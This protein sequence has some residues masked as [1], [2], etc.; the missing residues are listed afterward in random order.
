MTTQSK[1]RVPKAELTGLYGRL[2]TAYAKRMYGEVPDN[3]HVMWHN[4]KVLKGICGF[5]R[6]GPAASASRAATSGRWRSSA[7]LT[8][9]PAAGRPRSPGQ[10]AVYP[11][12]RNPRTTRLRRRESRECRRRDRAAAS[13][14][15]PIRR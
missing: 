15:L 10:W 3:A 4:R 7:I 6:G 14:R 13:P 2:V 11:A 5:V 8:E 9:A 1:F 12:A